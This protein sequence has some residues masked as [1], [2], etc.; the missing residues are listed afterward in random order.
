MAT[1]ARLVRDR[2]VDQAVERLPRP[3]AAVV[4]RLRREDLFMLAAGL[5]F[6][7]LLSI[8]PFTMLVLWVVS[9]VAG[10]DQVQQV[11]DLFGRL[12]PRHLGLDQA[13]DQVARIGSSLGVG[14]L[15]ALVWPA[16]AYGAGLFRAF[17]RLCPAA[18]ESGRGVRGRLRALV[19]VAVMPALVLVGLVGA[20]SGTA[21]LGRNW[22]ATAAGWTLVVVLGFLG[23]TV[24]SAVIYR[25]FSPRTIDRRG[26]LGGG[27]TAGACI[28]IFSALYVL[29][30]HF[31]TDFER[32]YATSGMAAVVLLGLWLF[33]A[34]AVILVGYQVAVE[35]NG[36]ADGASPLRRHR[37]GRGRKRPAG[38]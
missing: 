25:V 2:P 35:T 30:L 22:L 13:L 11:S 23:S 18:E 14:A 24:G 38:R 15:V 36:R 5:A 26:L 12:M 31:G 1:L 9:G 27:V 37:S 6:Y 16:S 3:V 7:A 33:L 10:D 21:L 20:Y 28:A 29:F 34:N 19:L 32:R 17:D 4:R 8:V